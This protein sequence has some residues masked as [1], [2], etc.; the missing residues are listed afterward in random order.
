MTNRRISRFVFWTVGMMCVLA[1]QAIAA[2]STTTDDGRVVPGDRAEITLSFAPLVREVG[3]AVVNVYTRTFLSGRSRVSPMFDDPFFKRFFGDLIPSLPETRREASS[4][5]SGV[6]V[7]A[8][9]TVVTNNH[10]VEGADEITVVLSDRREFKAR[11]VLADPKADLAVLAI[12]GIKEPLPFVEIRDSDELAVGDLVLAIGDPFGVGQTVTMGIVSALARTNVGVTDYSFFIQ[13]DASI[14]PGNSGGA[15]IGMDG[16]LV[17]IN[18]AIFSNQ[19]G[20]GGG[21]SVG[22]G[23]A[24][25]SNMVATVLRAARDGAVVRP[26]LGART[27]SVSPDLAENLGLPRPVGA[28]IN[29]VYPG[30]PADRAGLQAGDVVVAVDG[31]EVADSGGLRYRIA[32]RAPGEHVMIRVVRGGRETEVELDME[33]PAEIPP[34]D[35][36]DLTGRHPFSGARIAN[37]SPELAIEEG[38]DEMARGVVVLGLRRGTPA[39]QVGVRRG[40][41]IV[42][43]NGQDIDSVAVLDRALE[44]GRGGWEVTIRRDGKMLTTRIQG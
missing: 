1:A 28:L 3:P 29:D 12:E 24:V 5:G 14:N 10:V 4:L 22:I 21:G 33:P 17:G 34:A 15:L 36:R 6:I 41:V 9:G 16:R 23:F 27:Q 25:P 37:L 19:R 40:D 2:S 43:V 26:W 13:T 18:T 20:A 39:D 30:G 42:R 35:V 11:L 44:S 38:F 32:T 8:D 31:R 7:A